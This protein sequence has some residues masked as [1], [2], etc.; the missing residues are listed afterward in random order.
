[1]YVQVSQGTTILTIF[2]N[3]ELQSRSLLAKSLHCPLNLNHRIENSVK[4]LE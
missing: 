1:M 3:I 2:L 4:R